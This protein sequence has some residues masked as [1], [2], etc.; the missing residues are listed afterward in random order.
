MGSQKIVAIAGLGESRHLGVHVAVV[1][2][3]V[4]LREHAQGDLP[5]VLLR[6]RRDL[7][8]ITTEK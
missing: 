3:D 5:D 7:N 1:P 4:A 2:E 6:P 8:A